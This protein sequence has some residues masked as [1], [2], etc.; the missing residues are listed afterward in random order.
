MTHLM[1]IKCCGFFEIL[2]SQGPVFSVASITDINQNTD[3]GKSYATVTWSVP[4]ATD[5]SGNPA[6]V[7]ESHVPGQ[8]PIGTYMVVYTAKDAADNT[9]TLS[10]TIIITGLFFF[11]VKPAKLLKTTTTTTTTKLKFFTF[12]FLSTLTR[13]L[14]SQYVIT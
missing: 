14:R 6:T 10:F 4:T 12:K 9:A 13:D 2:D 1:Y 7:T 3:P 8:F 5:N 11:V